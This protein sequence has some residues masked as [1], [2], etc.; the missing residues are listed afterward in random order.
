MKFLSTSLVSLLMAAA[1]GGT[2]STA[3]TRQELVGPYLGQTPPGMIP[4]TF[5]P[6]VIST[7]GWEYG[8][9]FAPGMKELYW[10]R[11]VNTDTE[12][13]REFVVYEQKGDT[14][15]Q[16]VIGPRRGTPTLS[17]DGNIM[18]FGRSYKQ[19]TDG[20]WS[21]PKRL[22]PDFED[23]RIMRVT[24][25]DKGT[26]V[27]DEAK[28]DSVLRYSGLVDGV[29]EAPKP[30][31]EEINTGTWNA[32]PFI[33]PDESYIIWDG[34]RGDNVRD[35]DIYISFK[36]PDGSWGAAMKFGDAINTPV[37]EF[38]ASV[39]PDGKYMFFNRN[40]GPGNSA[41]NVDT[42]WVSTEVIEELR[43]K[44]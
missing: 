14:W 29:R 15:H 21:E 5:A 31:P 44:N 35:A 24:A 27:F 32:H 36:Q 16:R 26:Y 18:F 40:M 41:D 43:P 8:V 3:D 12:P 23:I 34:H 11:E 42:F 33:A 22:G 1:V 30:L 9:T 2:D 19:R 17:T 28:E 25:S 20:G 7:S 38:A 37:N 13:K 6:G 10:L 39:T 4:E